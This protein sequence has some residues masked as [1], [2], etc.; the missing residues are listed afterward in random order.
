MGALADA[1]VEERRQHR[2]GVIGRAA[3][4]EVVGGSAPGLLQPGNVGLEAAGGEDDAARG[5]VLRPAYQARGDAA[6]MTVLQPDPLHPPLVVDV[7]ADAL[8]VWGEDVHPHVAAPTEEGAE[9][10]L[11][12]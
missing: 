12:P 7:D 10:A 1:L 6:A 8:G 2:A 3:D 4:D 11:L 5:E 9:A